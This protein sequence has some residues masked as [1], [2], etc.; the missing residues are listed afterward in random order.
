MC[1]GDYILLLS[2]QSVSFSTFHLCHLTVW[3]GSYRPQLRLS[4]R[5]CRYDYCRY[6]CTQMYYLPHSCTH[7]LAPV[8]H[9][10]RRSHYLSLSNCSVPLFFNN[11]A[12]YICFSLCKQLICSHSLVRSLTD[13]TLYLSYLPLLYFSVIVSV[14][15]N[16][17]SVHRTYIV[18]SVHLLTY[19]PCHSVHS[20]FVLLR[21]HAGADRPWRPS[22]HPCKWLRISGV[23]H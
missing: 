8:F 15:L 5:L 12:Y 3:R 11:L 4:S 21:L 6:H 22:T 1:G 2:R 17:F 18:T 13:H 20:Y 14:Q 19:L 16:I 23:T 10:L 9:S 7:S